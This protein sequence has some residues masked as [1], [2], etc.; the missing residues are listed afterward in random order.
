LFWAILTC[1]YKDLSTLRGKTPSICSH[2]L[3]AS[4]S[5][6]PSLEVCHC[7]N[8]VI[9]L[10]SLGK[11]LASNTAPKRELEDEPGTS[12]MFMRE[13]SWSISLSRNVHVPVSFGTTSDLPL[14]H[15]IWRILVIRCCYL[16]YLEDTVL[17]IVQG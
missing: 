5:R 13:R 4:S 16:M 12:G 11:S 1:D 15:N 14:Y 17:L 10:K 3:R 8:G 9:V 7:P 2:W 6:W